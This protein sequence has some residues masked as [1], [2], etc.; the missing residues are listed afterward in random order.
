MKITNQNIDELKLLQPELTIIGNTI[1]GCFYLSASLESKTKGRGKKVACYPWNAQGA[2]NPRHINDHFYID[3][4]LDENLYP[5]RVIETSEKLLS[6]KGDILSEYWHVNSDNTLCM[7]IESDIKQKQKNSKSFA[8]FINEL[9]T[10]YF[11]YICYV[12]Q[13]GNEP[14]EAYRHGLFYALEKASEDINEN[15]SLILKI[16]KS[17]AAVWGGGKEWISL[18][19]KTK[20]LEIKHNS[21]CPFCQKYTLVRNCNFHKKQIKGYNKIIQYQSKKPSE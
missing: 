16:L 12:K 9:L 3:V 14:W 7:G 21:N 10:E 19:K 4:V 11:Y 20:A 8:N 1:S 17:D 18:L 15:A 6:W 13:F 2:N 5:S